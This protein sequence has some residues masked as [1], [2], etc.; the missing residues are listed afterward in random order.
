MDLE[1]DS[2]SLL[3]WFLTSRALRV[4]IIGDFAGRELFAIHGDALLLHCIS[5]AKVDFSG[6]YGLVVD[7]LFTSASMTPSWYSAKKTQMD[8]SSSM[9]FTPSKRFSVT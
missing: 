1:D 3:G 8:V 7:E 6:M 4:D 2:T 5:E 9:P